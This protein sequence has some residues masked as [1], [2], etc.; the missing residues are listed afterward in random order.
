MLLAK[1]NPINRIY[2]FEPNP[3]YHHYL[4]YRGAQCPVDIVSNTD[5]ACKDNVHFCLFQRRL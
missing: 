2:A 4:A 3:N 5:V 1:L